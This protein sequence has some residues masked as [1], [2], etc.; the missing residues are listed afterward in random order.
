MLDCYA[1]VLLIS[2]CPCDLSE[3]PSHIHFQLGMCGQF[4]VEHGGC[5]PHPDD[6]RF[7]PGMRVV[8]LPMFMLASSCFL[9]SLLTRVTTLCLLPAIGT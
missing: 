2:F 3:F 4:L 7:R 9:P 1:D 5:L 8:T 6:H